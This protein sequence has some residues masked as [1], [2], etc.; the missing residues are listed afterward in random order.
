MSPDELRANLRY[1]KT[2]GVVSWDGRQ[3]A[4]ANSAGYLR[5]KI[6]GRL[7]YAHRL[8]W[9]AVTGDWPAAGTDHIDGDRKNNRWAN[10]REA[11]QRLNNENLRAPR[12]HNTNG[13][14]G[15]EK[16][17]SGFAAR[18]RVR[19]TRLYLGT[20]RTA[21]KAHAAYVKA[22]RQLHEGCTI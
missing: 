3:A 15:I 6:G 1:D 19:G 18:I 11:D 12:S 20:F 10:L 14:L 16:N 22:K 9:L 4:C 21:E 2:T 8:A 13:K 7:Y 5:L 17:G